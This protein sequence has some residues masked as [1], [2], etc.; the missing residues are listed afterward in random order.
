MEEL[1]QLNG[2][3]TADT[4]HLQ[5][6]YKENELSISYIDWQEKSVKL[7]FKDVLGYR[8]GQFNNNTERN[9]SAYEVLN[10]DWLKE[11]KIDD[12]KKEYHH[13]KLAFNDFRDCVID[14]VSTSYI[15]I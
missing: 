13:Y 3:S 6:S 7:I 11:F 8:V 2:I 10:S 9:D 5:V 15:A 14:I 4:E 1:K 12:T